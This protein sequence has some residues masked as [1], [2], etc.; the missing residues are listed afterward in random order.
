MRSFI[1]FIESLS[2]V[3]SGRLQAWIVFFLMVLVLV[4]VT[5][6]YVLRNPLSIAEEFGGYLLVAITCMGLAFAWKHESHVRVEFLV[7]KLPP[8]IRQWLRLFTVVL[9]F[10]FTVFMVLACYELVSFSFMFGTRSGSWLR[11]PIAWPQIPMLIGAFLIFLQ[12]IAEIV[13]IIGRIHA[14]RWEE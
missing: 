7:N 8:Q 14:G 5:S 3:L 1:R 11:T 4:D 12:L 10:T 9:A 2:E 6:R 13:K